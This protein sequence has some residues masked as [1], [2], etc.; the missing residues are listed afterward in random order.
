MEASQGIV[1]DSDSQGESPWDSGPH[2]PSTGSPVVYPP[3]PSLLTERGRSFLRL[4]WRCCLRHTDSTDEEGIPTSHVTLSPRHPQAAL[5]GGRAVDA[6]HSPFWPPRDPALF[7]RELRH[8]P[9]PRA[10]TRWAVGLKPGICGTG[11]AGV[12][13]LVGG[14]LEER[15]SLCRFLL[16]SW[17]MTRSEG[18]GL[19]VRSLQRPAEPSGCSRPDSCFTFPP[20]L[21]F[22]TLPPSAKHLLSGTHPSLF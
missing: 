3:L 4:G 2:P 8:L 21:G 10:R 6:A 20:F 1:L 19:E 17:R 13:P 11:V 9:R 22:Q 7:S 5:R 15:N 14:R 16:L 12:N 18:L